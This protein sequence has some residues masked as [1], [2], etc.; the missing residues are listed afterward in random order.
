[1]GAP[2]VYI[3]YTRARMDTETD[4]CRVTP[5]NEALKSVH[6][7]PITSK[8]RRNIHREN[9]WRPLDTTSKATLDTRW[10]RRG[11]EGAANIHRLRIRFPRE[12]QPGRTKGLALLKA[13]EGG[14]GGSW[15]LKLA[16]RRVY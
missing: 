8:N 10:G 15:G 5:R 7:D 11:G 4:R 9:L 12:N 16:K 13:G 14:G 2:R 3:V 6:R 1:M